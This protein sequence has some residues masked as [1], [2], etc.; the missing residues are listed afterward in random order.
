M[1]QILLAHHPA[2][3][4][5][6]RDAPID[7]PVTLILGI[8]FDESLVS[9]LPDYTSRGYLVLNEHFATGIDLS[10]SWKLWAF[11]WNSSSFLF[12]E[13]LINFS[14][15]PIEDSDAIVHANNNLL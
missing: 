14:R 6:V 4:S 3:A 15:E 13:T 1:K 9:S 5:A 11:D 12:S 8:N 10:L 7:H 2:L